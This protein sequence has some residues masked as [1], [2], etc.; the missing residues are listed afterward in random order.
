MSLAPLHPWP[1]DAEEALRWQRRL[2]KRV[3]PEGDPGPV[4]Y[5][6]GCDVA[7][8]RGRAY[9]AALLFDLLT[10]QQM[11]SAWAQGEV[12]FPYVPGLLSFRELPL[13]LE[14]FERL[15]GP[16]P[17]LILCDGQ[18]IAHPRQMGLAAHLGLWLDRP[19]IG[20]AKSRLW[21]WHEPVPEEALR[22]RPLWAKGRL[23]GYALRTRHRGRLV[24]VSP[25]HRIG[26]EAA[27]RLVLAL[28]DGHRLPYPI[29]L[30]DR[31]A[32]ALA[33]QGRH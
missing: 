28:L 14:A 21:G 17:E 10:G 5:V 16:E 18:G 29:R 2:A 19:T 33:R 32:R 30:A 4:R 31:A 6:L 15:R 22:F 26:P 3:R 7:Y 20:V 27:L 1:E 11:A 8:G 12:R 25:G 24:Y 13:L 23:L 9:A